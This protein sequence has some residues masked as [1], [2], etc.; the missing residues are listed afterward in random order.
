MST[1]KSNEFTRDWTSDIADAW[2]STLKSRPIKSILEIGSYEG[3]TTL[4]MAQNLIESD[5]VIHCIDN[6]SWDIGV[7]QRFKCNISSVTKVK[8][9]VHRGRSVEQ[10]GLLNSTN[11]KFDLV[12]V[13]GSSDPKDRLLD[14][15]GAWS[16][17]KLN[18]IVIVDDYNFVSSDG[19]TIKYAVDAFCK[20]FENC[21][22]YQHIGRQVFIR[23]I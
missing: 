13:D 23:K 14:L 16:L 22:E 1:T 19:R 12:Y 21:I 6:W 18:G 10:L 5:G 15:C 4:W 7:E 3:R 2:K 17:V 9:I 20:V 8:V 11:H